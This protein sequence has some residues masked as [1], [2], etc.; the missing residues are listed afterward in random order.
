L[1]ISFS[2]GLLFAA[3][4]FMGALGLVMVLD[5]PWLARWRFLR[6]KRLRANAKWYPT[7]APW[8]LRVCGVVLVVKAGFYLREVA[9][10][11]F[12]G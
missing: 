8:V 11:L 10:V 3:S 5:A 4:M 6:A 9:F 12:F 1:P 7:L 2:L